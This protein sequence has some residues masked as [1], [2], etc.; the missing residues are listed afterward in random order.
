MRFSLFQARV[1][2]VALTVFA[3]GSAFAQLNAVM[4]SNEPHTADGLLARQGESSFEP[5]KFDQS[6]APFELRTNNWLGIKAPNLTG[7]WPGQTGTDTH[8][9]AKFDDPAYAISS[10][11][12]L[13]R[14]YQERYNA[15]S[16]KDILARYSPAGDCSGAPSLPPNKRREGG[17]CVENQAS[18]PVTAVRVAHAVGLQ[19]SDDL[20]LFGPKGQINHPDRLR[21]LI[22]AI[23]TQEVGVPY[24]PQ[25]PRGE[26]WIGCRIDDALY[27]R[28][29][30]LLGKHS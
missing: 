19:P 15:H 21:V 11:I 7:K 22:D 29:V 20:D 4:P 6:K 10:F 27:S 18:A 24:C 9:F 16:T 14:F 1:I 17:G 8:G 13:M 12:E 5:V 28:A 3:A 2:A 23:A 25:P 26:S 30:E